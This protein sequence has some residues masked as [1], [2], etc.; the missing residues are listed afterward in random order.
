M[1]VGDFMEYIDVHEISKKWNMKERKVTSLCRDGR[2]SGAKKKGK[3]WMIPSDS[4]KP[5]DK[6]T[7]DY[8]SFK[9]EIETNTSFIPYTEVGGEEKVITYYKEKYLKSPMY[10]AFTPY[11][12]CPIGAHVD[13]NLGHITGF[14][15]DKGIHF[16]YSIKNNGVIELE[17]LQYPKRAQWHVNNIPIEKENDWADPLRG[18]N[19]EL[20]KRYN[21]RFGLSAIIDGELP[22]GGLSSSSSLLITFINALSF[23]NNIHL[24]KEELIEIAELSEKKYL[25]ISNGKLDEYCEVYSKKNHLLYVDMLNNSYELIETPKN[26]KYDI[27]IFFSGIEKG[28]ESNN[29]NIRTDELRS[30]AYLLKSLEGIPLTRFKDT[31][32]RD[33]PIEI[34][35]KYENKLP[36]NYKKRALHW[37]SEN[38]RVQQSLIAYKKGNIK[39]FGKLVTESGESSINNWETGSKELIDLFNILK[40][41]DGVY[42]T[43]FSGSGFKG[44]CIAFLGPNKKE[45]ILK[46]VE[47]QYTHKY[48]KLKEK[49]SHH[50]CHTADGI[51]L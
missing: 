14:A 9:L 51:K 30:C 7:K 11:R 20:N 47:K 40:E 33:I 12:I 8:D 2:I 22:I 5:L 46:E 37:Y 3:T 35:H 19:L 10:T 28:I 38:E 44:C 50:I 25:E 21:L 18:A 1:L 24:S 43:R 31:N 13:H 16:A 29:Y 32:M 36:K 42:G 26:M 6:R 27:G 41:T 23:I 45:S 15:I 49:Y 4:L 39:E 48:P 34:F 17:S